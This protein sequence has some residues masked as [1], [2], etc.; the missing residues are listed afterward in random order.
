MPV[1]HRS[2]LLYRA[3]LGTLLVGFFISQTIRPALPVR[4][5]T[6]PQAVSPDITRLLGVLNSFPGKTSI[7]IKQDGRDLV[8]VN[9]DTP[10]AVGSSFKIPVLLGLRKQVD[11]GLHRWD[12]VVPL[13]AEWKVPGSA[14]SDLFDW[15][16]GEPFTI[17]TY[18]G[19]MISKSDNTAT[20]AVIGIVGRENIEPYTSR[21]QPLLSTHDL[22]ILK[23]TTNR[24]LLERWR[25]ADEAGRRAM[26]PM[27]DTMP[28]A[29]EGYLSV[30]YALDA[31]WFF[32][33][34]E[35]CSL[36]GQVADLPAM[37]IFPGP[38]KAD[39]WAAVAYKGGSEPGVISTTTWVQSRDGQHTYCISGTWNNDQTVVD[40]DTFVKEIMGGLFAALANHSAAPTSPLGL[41]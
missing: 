20:D 13:K 9:A 19:Y 27:L 41:Q 8:A 7:V 15:A 31:E 2:K 4:A 25:S 37:R 28:L 18:A 33:N 38:A 36:I 17:E 35:L 39:D 24:S 11:A 23:S 21:N 40:S 14:G 6:P 34:H 3:A 30:P 12:E 16:A 32:T 29:A 5:Q 26:L 10:L 1:I 22:F